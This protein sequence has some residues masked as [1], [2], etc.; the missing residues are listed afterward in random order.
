MATTV[1]D[2]ID[3]AIDMIQERKQHPLPP[4]VEREFALAITAL[5]D[6]Q[7]RYTRGRAKQDSRFNPVDLDR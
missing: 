6:A 5:E 3:Y 4:G 2:Y 7:M 1:K